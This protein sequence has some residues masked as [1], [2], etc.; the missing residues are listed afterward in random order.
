MDLYPEL[1]VGGYQPDQLQ[2]FINDAF[3][4][5]IIP[6]YGAEEGFVGWTREYKTEYPL[7]L[8]DLIESDIGEYLP[9]IAEIKNFRD[10]Q[11]TDLTKLSGLVT[12]LNNQIRNLKDDI[13]WNDKTVRFSGANVLKNAVIGKNDEYINIDSERQAALA[14]FQTSLSQDTQNY[15]D[16]VQPG[17][18]PQYSWDD[19]GT[20]ATTSNVLTL[21]GNYYD[22]DGF[23]ADRNGKA[24]EDNV[25][26]PYLRGDGTRLFQFRDDLFEIQQMI[27]KAGGPAPKTLGVWDANLAKF[28]E[29]VLAYANDSRSWEYDMENGYPDVANQWNSALNEY[30][31]QNESGTQLAE[32]LNIAGYSTIA[33]PT[34]SKSEVKKALDDLYGG[35][36][37]KATAKMY[38]E[39]GDFFVNL[40]N[41]AAQREVEIETNANYLK[42][43][44]LG[45]KQYD[46]APQPG[47]EGFNEYEAAKADGR[48]YEDKTGVYVIP[49]ATEIKQTM[50]VKEPIDITGTMDDYLKER[51]SKRIGAVEDRTVARENAGLFTNNYLSLSRT[52]FAG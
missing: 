16:G 25:K 4:R 48:V 30:I 10:T 51:Y 24:L 46:K 45:T 28:M 19:S 26:A 29:N 39:D 42:E 21:G 34:P 41:T 22:K 11:D 15:F 9:V 13:Q 18:E 33:Q 40:S 2:N 7:S 17:G 38:K 32:I 36:G 23:Y 35:Y 43:L 1:V 31:V 47:E 12:V 20:Q 8:N 6:A 50:G 44:I 52:G 37:L 27:I 49:L 5:P 3:T 14:T